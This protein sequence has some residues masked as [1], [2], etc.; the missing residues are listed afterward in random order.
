MSLKNA[1]K[2]CQMPVTAFTVSK[3][4]RQNQQGGGRGGGEL[5]LLIPA[6]L[7]LMRTKSRVK[8]VVQGKLVL[9]TLW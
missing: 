8:S 4:L 6:R 1:T 3:L 2:R 7:G 5:S 9:E